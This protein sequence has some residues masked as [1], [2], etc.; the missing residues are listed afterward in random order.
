[1]AT[2]DRTQPRLFLRRHLSLWVSSKCTPE[3]RVPRST[4]F[5]WALRPYSRE[6]GLAKVVADMNR[7]LGPHA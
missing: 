1:M 6:C 7:I 3:L 2:A 4:G 5:L